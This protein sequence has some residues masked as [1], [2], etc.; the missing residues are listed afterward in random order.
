MFAHISTALLAL[1]LVTAPLVLAADADDVIFPLPTPPAVLEARATGGA[2]DCYAQGGYLNCVTSHTSQTCGKPGDGPSA[3]ACACRQ[4]TAL[5]NCYTSACP[6]D[7]YYSTFFAGVSACNAQGFGG[8]SP[9]TAAGGGGGGGNGAAT[10]TA[11][12]AGAASTGKNAGAAAKPVL[13]GALV[14]ALGVAGWMA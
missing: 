9:V 13:V 5:F 7:S 6:S 2:G 1:S 8:A 14:V 11:G 4:V 10:G 3:T 12:G